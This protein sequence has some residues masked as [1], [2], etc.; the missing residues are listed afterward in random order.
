[1]LISL[2]LTGYTSFVIPE[3]VSWDMTISCN[4]E[5][6]K[7]MAATYCYATKGQKFVPEIYGHPSVLN[8]I[9]C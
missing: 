6:V 9:L 5:L 8:L 4:I 3:L 7:K 1:M 2:N